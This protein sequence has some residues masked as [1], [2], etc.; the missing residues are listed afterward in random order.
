LI[1]CR[2]QEPAL[3]FRL[4]IRSSGFVQAAIVAE[5]LS[6]LFKRSRLHCRLEQRR[7]HG[8]SNGL[9]EL[10][11]GALL[12]SLPA[13]ESQGDQR[14][15]RI[16]MPA[17]EQNIEGIDCLPFGIGHASAAEQ[18]LSQT[19]LIGGHPHRVGTNPGG[20]ELNASREFGGCVV[21]AVLVEA[22]AAPRGAQGCPKVRG[23][24]CFGRQCGIR[25]VETTGFTQL[26]HEPDPETRSKPVRGVLRHPFDGF[27]GE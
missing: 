6:F 12:A 27:G 2:H 18:R 13:K 23:K 11:I 4:A 1:L 10:S 15:R 17:G 7:I 25:I 22:D 3:F 21:K 19:A 5:A 14:F 9:F 16:R 20:S 26:A 24:V 8:A